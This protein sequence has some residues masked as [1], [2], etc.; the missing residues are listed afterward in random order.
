MIQVAP[1][2]TFRGME[3]SPAL[4]QR[5]LERIERL[6][7]FHPRITACKVAVNIPHRH[8][9]QGNIFEVTLVVLIP[10]HDI[11]VN[12]SSPDNQAHEDPYVV[13]RDAFDEAERQLEDIARKSSSHRT[14]QPGI[15]A[16]G[17]VD[18]LFRDDGF[19]FLSTLD[20]QDIYF[21]MDR[22][23][24]DCAAKLDIGTK[25]RFVIGDSDTGPYAHSI[26]ILETT[27]SEVGED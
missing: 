26:S 5:I 13:V 11:V 2:I 24:G 12:R 20:D 16:Q 18:R 21:N 19:G 8:Q 9:T 10:G 6:E 25:V 15:A 23:S 7:Q 4:K 14:R 27:E 3:T 17:R 22:L 1:I